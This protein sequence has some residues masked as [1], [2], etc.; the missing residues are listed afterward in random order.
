MKW[1]FFYEIKSIMK[2]IINSL[3][4]GILFS[5]TSF[6][7]CTDVDQEV[8]QDICLTDPPNPNEVCIEIYQ[9]VCGCNEI[10]YSNSCFAEGIVVS[11][12]EG[13]CSN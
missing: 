12:T 9:P 3:I 4:L 10:T 11:W 6:T 7:S 5:L 13:A 1:F 2:S 8:T